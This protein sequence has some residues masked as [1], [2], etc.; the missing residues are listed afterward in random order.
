MRITT[1]HHLG[2]TIRAAQAADTAN[3]RWCEP[4]PRAPRGGDS[5]ITFLPGGEP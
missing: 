3:F 1:R 5:V 4:R 2:R